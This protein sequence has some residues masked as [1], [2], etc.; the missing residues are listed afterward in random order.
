M[1]HTATSFET[2]VNRPLR[3]V[4]GRLKRGILLRGF[5]IVAIAVVVLATI[6]L[7]LD[8]LLVLDIGPR[9]AMLAL[10]C[11]VIGYQIW[12][13]ILLPSRIRIEPEDVAALLERHDP[14]LH[15]AVISAV[16]FS[17]KPAAASDS[18]DM[19]QRL[20]TEVQERFKTLRPDSLLKSRHTRSPITSLALLCILAASLAARSELAA[21]Y[22]SRDWLLRDTPW[23]SRTQI[24]VEGLSG[25][26]IVWPMGDDL[27]LVATAQGDRP[28]SL[29]A[30]VKPPHGGTTLRDMPR[31]GEDQFI[32]E[33]G[34]LA[35]SL[36]VRFLIGR[37]GVD[38]PT[39]WYDVEAVERPHVES[40]EITVT[41][42]TYAEQPKSTL[43]AGQTAIEA[44]RGST[45]SIAAKLNKPVKSAALRGGGE[46]RLPASLDAGHSKVA[47]EFTP[48]LGGSYYFDLTDAGGLT[49]LHPVPFAVRL[50]N[51]PPPKV[52]LAMPGAGEMI[53]PG[54]VLELEIECEDNVALKSVELRYQL[55]HESPGPT[56]QPDSF[57][58]NIPGFEPKTP[59]FVTRHSWPL[60]GLGLKTGD[61]MSL[62]VRATDYQPLA[63]GAD[64]KS[65]GMSDS[66]AYSLRVVSPEE[67]L[68]E[69]GRRESE[70]RREFEMIVKSQ[71]DLKKR[72]LDLHDQA[73]KGFTPDIAAQ[74]SRE[75]AAQRAQAGRIKTVRRQFEQLLAELKTNQLDQPA[76]RKRLDGGV[77]QPLGRIATHDCSNAADKMAEARRGF[78]RKTADAVEQAQN[79]LLEDMN[80]VLAAMLKWEG[81][82]EAVSLLRDVIRLQSD[83]NRQTQGR[84]EEQADKLF[85]EPQEKK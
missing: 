65:P 50:M 51:D 10:V 79:T 83:L 16:S 70:W 40:A 44:L 67:L 63:A 8:F 54:A 36:K 32:L 38:E 25:N 33:Y 57:V 49:D 74:Y 2:Q 55:S 14:S 61:Q 26:K 76:V 53:I 48:N 52:R 17:R 15:D 81:Y 21:T 23:P 85:G 18:R 45:I 7:I 31:R 43:P 47:A 4:A 28:P 37:F 68:A 60:S 69:L 58:E 3:R 34:P 39:A 75:E 20:M 24:L 19:I 78:D 42:P 11:G 72:V 71:A 30:E 6:Q 29:R 84:V 82:N 35:S 27:T 22:I 5:G 77:I 56:S 9:I 62:L 12:H 13:R 73:A 1:S 59:R 46:Q 66:I 80:A 41:P 64:G